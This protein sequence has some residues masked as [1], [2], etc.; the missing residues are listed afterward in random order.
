MFV[1]EKPLILN[2]V[3]LGENSK[4]GSF[5][6]IGQ[7]VENEELK[8]IIGVNANIRSHTVIYA[9]NVIGD[10]FQTGHH[11]FIQEKNNIGNNVSIGTLSAILKF[12]KLDDNVRIHTS[13]FIPEY[14]VIKKGAW[15]GPCVSIT[16]TLHPTCNEAKEC[17]KKT[18][19]IIEEEAIIGANST[20]LAG[21]TIGKRA[22]IGAGSV[23]TKDVPP[24]E[25]VVGNPAKAIKKRS[26]IEC[27]LN[28]TDKPYDD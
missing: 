16:N 1:S 3:E 4:I 24:N 22:I 18:F 7:S 14:T 15:I 25:V 20:L 23:V 8:T 11:A 9:G 19:C 21:I 27:P 6:L 28:L 26:D 10:N 12:C 17:M 13:A 5:C 2:G